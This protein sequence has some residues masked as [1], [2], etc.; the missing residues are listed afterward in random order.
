MPLEQLHRHGPV[1][2]IEDQ[3]LIRA[4]PQQQQNRRR[5][6]NGNPKAMNLMSSTEH[7]Q[8]AKPTRSAFPQQPTHRVFTVRDRQLS[9]ATV[10]RQQ[11]QINGADTLLFR[12][13]EKDSDSQPG[14]QPILRGSA[15]IVCE[16]P[17]IA[18]LSWPTTIS[19]PSTSLLPFDDEEEFDVSK[20]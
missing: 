16:L 10:R 6:S 15:E 20:N 9:Q 19:L 1:R 11:E 13:H 7:R 3:V 5:F 4:R 8:S 14:E 12:V 18:N 2:S 17:S